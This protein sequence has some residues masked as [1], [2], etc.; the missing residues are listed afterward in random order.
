MGLISSK[1][2]IASSPDI[3]EGYVVMSGAFV[4]SNCSIG[5]GSNISEGAIVHA[6]GYPLFVMLSE[7][8]RNDINYAISVLGH[9]NIE[10]SNVL[11]D[12]GYDSNQLLDYIYVHD[13]EPRIP[14]KKGDKFKRYCDWCLYKERYL[15]KKIFS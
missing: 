10:G 6:Y 13:G 3:A 5:R 14:S 15:I 2:M 12:R 9:I 4:Q 11:A 7:G 8:Q 1:A